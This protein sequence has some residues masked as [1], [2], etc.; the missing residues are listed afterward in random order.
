MRK[1]KVGEELICT[2][3]YP[4]MFPN[5][6]FRVMV[7]KGECFTVIRISYDYPVNK[8][9]IEKW[10]IHKKGMNLEFRLIELDKYFTLKSKVRN[11]KIKE[12]L[13]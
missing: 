4:F 10:Y 3:E 13:Q 8:Y 2:K 6:D 7:E 5:P 9:G 1:P 12:L 11:N